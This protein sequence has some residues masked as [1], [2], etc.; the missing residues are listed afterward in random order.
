MFVEG[1]ICFVIIGNKMRTT[2]NISDIDIAFTV[3]F[4][5]SCCTYLCIKPFMVG[6][7]QFTVSPRISPEHFNFQQTPAAGL[8]LMSPLCHV[9]FWDLHNLL[10]RNCRKQLFLREKKQDWIWGYTKQFL[11]TSKY[12]IESKSKCWYKQVF[13]HNFSIYK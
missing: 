10:C 1:N 5:F 3:H 11:T 2:V 13:L 7:K 9:F 12:F 8:D 4:Y 6:K